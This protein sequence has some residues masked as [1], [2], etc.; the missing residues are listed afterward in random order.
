MCSHS[1][2][3]PSFRTTPCK[4]CFASLP[5]HC[6]KKAARGLTL[7]RAPAHGWS[8]AF[9]TLPWLEFRPCVALR[10]VLRANCHPRSLSSPPI[11]LSRANPPSLCRHSG[12]RRESCQNFELLSAAWAPFVSTRAWSDA[13]HQLTPGAFATPVPGL[14]LVYCSCVDTLCSPCSVVPD[15]VKRP[16][17]VNHDGG[18]RCNAIASPA[19][20]RFSCAALVD[21]FDVYDRC[22]SYA[23]N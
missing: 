7:L 20:G 4:R 23:R 15:D 6:V 12:I 1:A 3:T 21:L 17:C 9:E 18:A 13:M 8:D 16:L 2:S 22:P 19:L 10:F 14:T 11:P 5:D